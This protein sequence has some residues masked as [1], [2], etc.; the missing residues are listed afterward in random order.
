MDY[1]YSR[2]H[3]R[4]PLTFEVGP[5]S[6]AVLPGCVLITTPPA[7]GITLCI[8]TASFTPGSEVHR[9]L[10]RGGLNAPMHAW[11]RPDRP[12]C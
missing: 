8:P 3:V 5:C 10:C 2:L 12:D 11:L 1:M 9:L 4:Y 6:C 7:P